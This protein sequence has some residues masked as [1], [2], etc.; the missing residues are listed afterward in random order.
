MSWRMDKSGAAVFEPLS[1]GDIA[2]RDEE[3]AYLDDG[4]KPWRL[5]NGVLD[6]LSR[7][8]PW[9]PW[10]DEIAA[11]GAPTALAGG[12]AGVELTPQP[13]TLP[14]IT[15]GA[16]ELAL[17]ST[18]V[19]TPI[20]SNPQCP[21]AYMLRAWG[22]ATTAATQGSIL[23]NARLGQLVTSPLLGASVTAIQT[24][25]QTT[26]N[27]NLFGDLLLRTGG[28][29]TTGNATAQFEYS[30]ATATTGG[31]PVLA[32]T[33][34]IIGNGLTITSYESDAALANGLWMG[35]IATTSTTNTFIPLA[36]IWA[37]WN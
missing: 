9:K 23:F 1:P 5:I 31:G 26:T 12:F 34:Q 37:S 35:G 16:T 19:N 24:A 33:N 22:Y 29:A 6:S 17:W 2:C 15:M 21:K 7:D 4:G 27:W 28:G 10:L 36:V 25:S 3:I 13:M 14:T 30:Q 8:R 32:A 18:S 11:A 20:A